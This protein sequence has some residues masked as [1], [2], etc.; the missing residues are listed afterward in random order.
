MNG[1]A[2]GGEDINM[3]FHEKILPSKGNNIYV[4]QWDSIKEKMTWQ[5]VEKGAEMMEK[6]TMENTINHVEARSPIAITDKQ[7]GLEKAHSRQ[8]I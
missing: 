3:V 7:I 1:S 4:G 5:A 2:S 6:F 8:V